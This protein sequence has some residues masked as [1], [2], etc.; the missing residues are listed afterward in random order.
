MLTLG[1]KDTIFGQLSSN[2]LILFWG[3]GGIKR[4]L[5]VTIGI[6][7]YFL[8]QNFCPSSLSHIGQ[9]WRD[10]RKFLVELDPQ[11]FQQ[12]QYFFFYFWKRQC[13]ILTPEKL[14]L[15]YFVTNIV[16]VWNNLGLDKPVNRSVAL[17]R[18]RT[19]GPAGTESRAINRCLGASGLLP[20]G[21]S[22]HKQRD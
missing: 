11:V 16:A 14:E 7:I 15:F 8:R 21:F 9:F 17:G 6:T 10:Q 12:F 22:L 3:Q 18:F 13:C 2:H 20:V 4:G 1:S 19:L 5:L